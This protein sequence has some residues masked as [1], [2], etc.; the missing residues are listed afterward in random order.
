MYKIVICDSDQNYIK[1]LEGIIR[2]CNKNQ[3]DLSFIEFYSGEEL[4][5]NL[6]MDSDVLFM[7]IKLDGM[8]GNE[9]AVK[10]VEARY[11]GLLIQFSDTVMPTLETI[12]ISPYR[13]LLKQAGKKAVCEEIYEILAEMDRQ[14]ARFALEASYR[15]EKIIIR[16][17]DIVYITHHKKGSVLHLNQEYQGQ[18]PE[19]QLITPYKFRELLEML[20]PIGFVCPHQSYLV[21]LR[22]VSSFNQTSELVELDGE[23]MSV[24]RGRIAQFAKDFARYIDQ[25]Y[26]EK[27]K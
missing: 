10:A 14:K 18:Y 22:Y 16:T 11:Q 3:R 6:P 12:K 7:N 8:D 15:R 4:L 20:S 27:L 5:E 19:G 1:E 2:E 23:Q 17:M 25:S 9:A 26:R 13:Y 21:N 24:A